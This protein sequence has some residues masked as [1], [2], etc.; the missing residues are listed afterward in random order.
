MIQKNI[1]P[2][3]A[4]AVVGEYRFAF[5]GVMSG[6]TISQQLLRQLF[7]SGYDLKHAIETSCFSIAH[8]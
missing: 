1:P 3:A 2:V 5:F 8:A 7:I 6:I 4:H